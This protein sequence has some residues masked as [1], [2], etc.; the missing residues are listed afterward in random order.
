MILIGEIKLFPHHSIPSGW[1][2]C[3]GSELPVN[4]YKELY[5]VIGNTYGGTVGIS[6]VLPNIAGRAIIGAGQQPGLSNYLVGDTTG[7]AEETIDLNTLPSHNHNVVARISTAGS[8]STYT[9]LANFNNAERNDG[10]SQEFV[11]TSTTT[12]I[13]TM[14][15][16]S[17]VSTTSEELPHENRQPYMP[18]YFCIA[19]SGDYPVFTS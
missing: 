15:S 3:D 9:H 2:K 19:F 4:G 1:L 10:I 8:I 14:N 13:K 17:I 16:Q 5:S 18:V 6:F 11:Y 12:P 7:T